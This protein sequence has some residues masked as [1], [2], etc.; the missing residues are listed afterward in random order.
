[1][2]SVIIPCYNAELTLNRCFESLKKQ[3]YQDLELIFIDDGSTDNTLKL[4]KS[5]KKNQPDMTIII[6]TQKNQGVSAA[7]NA[8]LQ[9]ATREYIA[10]VDPDDWVDP[11][12]FSTLIKGMTDDVD[13]SVVGVLKSTDKQSNKKL[14]TQDTLSSSA[15][16]ERMFRDVQVKGY[17]CNKL[18]RFDIIQQH[19]LFFRKEVSVMEDLEFNTHYWHFIRAASISSAQLYHYQIEDNSAMNATWSDKKKTVIQ[20]FDFMR[21]NGVLP[22]FQS[23]I[24]ELDYVRSLLWLVGQLYRKGSREDIAANEEMIFQLLRQKKR[25]FLY[26]GYKTGLKYY[27]SYLIFLIN[28][29]MLRIIIR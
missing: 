28:K 14:I 23:E 11:Q 10:F 26:K 22:K 17:V 20:A 13:L 1:M 16:F 29:K 25:L 7:R 3:T 18:Y 5:I 21:T 2:I 24:L 12:F 27:I 9:L 15:Y 4:L 8:G 6:K 19:V